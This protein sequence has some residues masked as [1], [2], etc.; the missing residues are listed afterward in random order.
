LMTGGGVRHRSRGPTSQQ[1]QQTLIQCPL[2]SRQFDRSVVEV[3]AA[4][5]EGRDPDQVGN[6]S[7]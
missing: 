7:D 3:H 6:L 1:N 2:C 5:C 4:T